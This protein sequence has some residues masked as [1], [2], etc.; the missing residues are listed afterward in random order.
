VAEEHELWQTHD[1]EVKKLNVEVQ[2]DLTKQISQ[3]KGDPEKIK[4]DTERLQAEAKTRLKS[5]EDK[6]G[7]KTLEQA[8]KQ[9][10]L[11]NKAFKDVDFFEDWAGP[12]EQLSELAQRAEQK[13]ENDLRRLDEYRHGLG[14]SLRKSIR[15]TIDVEVDELDPSI[16]NR[17]AATS[18]SAPRSPEGSSVQAG[19]ACS[20]A[21]PAEKPLS[22][23]EEATDIPGQLA[24]A[25]TC[26]DEHLASA[27]ESAQTPTAAPFPDERRSPENS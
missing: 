9:V 22:C 6:L 10:D 19:A 27:S 26:A 25:V 12:Y 2:A 21:T 15:E 1:D 8:K 13:F 4:A 17:G 5:A 23:A 16:N 24:A 20:T 14:E 18:S 7:Q 11:I 3:L